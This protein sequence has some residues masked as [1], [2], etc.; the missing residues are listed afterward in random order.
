MVFLGSMAAAGAAALTGLS[1][2]PL[3]SLREVAP[4]TARP[5]PPS[6]IHIPPFFKGV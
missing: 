1:P 4:P 3:G 6:K 5:L 2:G